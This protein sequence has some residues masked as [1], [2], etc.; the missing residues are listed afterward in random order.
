MHLLRFSACLTSLPLPSLQLTGQC[1][2]RLLQLQLSLLQVL[3]V[4]FGSKGH[5]HVCVDDHEGD[6][7]DVLFQPGLLLHLDVH[8]SCHYHDEDLHD[9]D[10]LGHLDSNYFQIYL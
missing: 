10:G 5:V 7:V 3:L 1:K 4:G 2:D 8:P 9:D 6:D